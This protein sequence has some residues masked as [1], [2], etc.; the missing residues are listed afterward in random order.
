VSKDDIT[1]QSLELGQ[2][3]TVLSLV[4]AFAVNSSIV[5]VASSSFS[6]SVAGG[7]VSLEDAASLSGAYRLLQPALGAAS[8]FLFAAALLAS[9]QSSTFTGTLAGQVV[10]EGFLHVRLPPFAR[11]LVTRCV[12]ILP[13]AAAVVLAGD[14]GLNRLLVLSQVTLSFQL[15]F[16][17]LPLVYFATAPWALGPFTVSRLTG[18]TGWAI[19]AFVLSL[20]AYMLYTALTEEGGW[21]G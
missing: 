20:N 5:V 21:S 17:I 4:G 6:A 14:A 1:R 15:P 9:G 16:A 12:A 11:R 19:C 3:D 10:M 18:A 7:S 8:S 13:A 2:W